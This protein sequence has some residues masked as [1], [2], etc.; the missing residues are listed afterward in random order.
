MI[1]SALFCL[2]PTLCSVLLINKI[3]ELSVYETTI[4]CSYARVATSFIG[5]K[6]NASIY[7]SFILSIW[8]VLSTFANF[9]H[10]FHKTPLQTF[11]FFNIYY[12]YGRNGY[13]SAGELVLWQYSIKL[14]NCWQF[15]RLWHYF[16]LQIFFTFFL[17]QL[18]A[19]FPVPKSK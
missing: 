12:N 4:S 7:A 17:R 19:K 15:W 16:L 11:L 3:V 14:F 18:A 2:T 5:H 1:R 8:Y 13:L 9:F 10:Y 6:F